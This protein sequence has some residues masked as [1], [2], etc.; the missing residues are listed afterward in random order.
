[1][2][3]ITARR[4]A[5]LAA[6]LL[7]TI[8]AAGCGGAGRAVR[9]RTV[10]IRLT[11]YRLLPQSITAPP[12]ELTLIVRNMGHRT[13]NLVLTLDGNDIAA[14]KPLWPGE[15]AKLKV[16]LPPGSY[17]LASTVL[18]DDSLGEYGTLQVS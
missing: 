7:S 2:S 3:P 8:A 17:Q 5:V 14:T 16:S 4:L 10:T 6:A 13:H 12:G 18:N 15:H 1:M 11:E 9:H